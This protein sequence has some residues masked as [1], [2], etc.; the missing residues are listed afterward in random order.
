MLFYLYTNQIA[1]KQL[2]IVIG[3]TF[4]KS[5]ERGVKISI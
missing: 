5:K 3:M 2:L 4:R 1:N